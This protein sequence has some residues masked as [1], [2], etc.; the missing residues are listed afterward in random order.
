MSQRANP[1]FFERAQ[2]LRKKALS[3]H[4]KALERADVANGIRKRAE[5]LVASATQRKTRGL[6]P[7]QSGV[8][9]L[10]IDLD[11]ALTF[12][13]IALSSHKDHDK[14]ARNQ[15]NARKA[16]DTVIHWKDRLEIS[17]PDALEIEAKLQKLRAALEEL[18]ERL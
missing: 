5:Q 2:A 14:R 15:A 6:R 1:K 7:N 4:M 9:F 17:Q 18:G 11:I 12:V 3:L 13:K 16:H 10:K 8:Q